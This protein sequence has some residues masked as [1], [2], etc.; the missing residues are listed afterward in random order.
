MLDK[1]SILILK[2]NIL[3]VRVKIKKEHC[4]GHMIGNLTTSLVKFC[5]IW[6]H[7][8]FFWKWDNTNPDQI[9]KAYPIIG[10]RGLASS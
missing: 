7:N 5:K 9:T 3:H 8:T 4:P 6:P 10:Q 1:F 2:K